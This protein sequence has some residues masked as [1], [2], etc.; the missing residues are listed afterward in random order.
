MTTT[1]PRRIVEN[2]PCSK[3]VSP[4]SYLVFALIAG[5]GCYLDLLSKHWVFQWRGLPGE[6]PIWWIWNGIVGIETS[7]NQGALFGL[8]QGRVFLFALLSVVALLGII[9]WFVWAGAGHDRF[10]TLTLACVS[11]GILGNLYDRLGLWTAAF[12][13]LPRIHAVRDWIRLSYGEFVWPNFNLA[14]SLLVCGALLLVWHAFRA[15]QRRQEDV[16]PAPGDSQ[17]LAG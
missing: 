12:D 13:G 2:S 3:P 10:L 11:G 14:D 9:Y 16:A 5:L 15:P 8:G 7:L 1:D 6:Q 4:G 17:T